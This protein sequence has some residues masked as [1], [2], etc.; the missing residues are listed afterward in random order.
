MH[1][2]SITTKTYA[3]EKQSFFKLLIMQRIRKRWWIPL[4]AFAISG[5]GLW[6]WSAG[7]REEFYIP[8]VILLVYVVGMSLLTTWRFV[9]SKSNRIYYLNRYY[10]MD[11]DKVSSFVE[12]GSTNVIMIGNF[13][14]AETSGEY[15]LLYLSKVQSIFIPMSVFKT[16]E[17]RQWFETHVIGKI[18]MPGFM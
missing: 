3:I 5:T 4:I 11:Y 16:P 13:I 14:K 6:Y 18:K 17:D 8:L 9:N 15:Y 1:I 10:V 2:S 12:D 7:H